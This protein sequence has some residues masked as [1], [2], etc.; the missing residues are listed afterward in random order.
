VPDQASHE[1]FSGDGAMRAETAKRPHPLH[2]DRW[3][4]GTL[5]VGNERAKTHGRYSTRAPE[6]TTDDASEAAPTATSLY[7]DQLERDQGGDDLPAV[8]RAYCQRLT[9]LEALLRSIAANLVEQGIF[10]ARGRPRSAL[11]AYLSTVGTWDRVAMRLGLERKLKDV[12]DLSLNDYLAVDSQT[13]PNNQG[14]H[15]D[16]PS[17]DRPDATGRPT[18]TD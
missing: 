16:A 15:S 5:R 12:R 18:Q 11:S 8:T 17:P 4:D 3:A 7:R 6:L 2:A 13:T 14:G 9:E 1:P 10:T